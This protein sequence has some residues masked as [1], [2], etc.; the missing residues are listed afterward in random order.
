[1]LL[2]SS[3]LACGQ[4]SEK[5][6][7]ASASAAATAVQLDGMEQIVL[8]AGCFWCIEAVFQEL[9][10]VQTVESGYSNGSKA[11]APT[12]KEVCTGSTGYAEVARITYDPMAVSFPEIL[13]VFWQTHDPT[14]VNRQGNDVGTQYRSGIFYSNDEQRKTAEELKAELD[15]SGAWYAPIVTEIAALAHFHLAENYHQ[16]YYANNP[17]QGYCRYVIQPKLEKFRKVFKDKVKKSSQ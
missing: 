8:G 5:M 13:E 6:E 11:E 16:D 14:T 17:D 2:F 1:M 15:K 7:G 12:Y 10:G 9:E 4:Q 3:L